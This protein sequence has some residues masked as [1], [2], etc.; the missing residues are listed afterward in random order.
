MRLS[1]PAECLA[2]FLVLG[3]ECTAVGDGYCEVV[4]ANAVA[5]VPCRECG[6]P[7]EF[8]EWTR[9]G[10]ECGDCFGAAVTH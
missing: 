2:A 10:A 5:K 8:R 7:V 4:H 9:Y 1:I 6:E 3:W